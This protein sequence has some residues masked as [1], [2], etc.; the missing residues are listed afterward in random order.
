MGRDVKRDYLIKKAKD[1][2]NNF[3]LNENNFNKMADDKKGN[4]V[5]SKSV[6]PD[7]V[8]IEFNNSCNCRVFIGSNV[9]GSFSININ[10]DNSTV[11]IGDN[12]HLKQTILKSE[13][14]NDFI[15]LGNHVIT[16]GAVAF[17]SGLRSG[18]SSSAIIVG[19]DCMFSHG[20]TVRNTDAHPIWSIETMQQ[21]NKPKDFIYIE[22][23]V[24]IG[25][26]AMILKDV[27]IGACSIVAAGS[28]VTKSAERFSK[29]YG[30]PSKNKVD[31]TVFWSRSYTSEAKKTAQYFYDKYFC[32]E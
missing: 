6:I 24:W 15:V 30:S 32:C 2:I 4:L 23:H 25:Q 29:I 10:K 21:V 14:I 16:S 27:H 19:D 18:N 31:A 26:G 17:R 13:C 11:Y 8:K 5:L 12:C 1:I 9:R 7:K 3:D 22:P 28:I 20:I